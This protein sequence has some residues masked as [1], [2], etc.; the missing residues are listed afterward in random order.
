[1]LEQVSPLGVLSAHWCWIHLKALLSSPPSLKWDPIA[2][3]IKWKLSW[4]STILDL[5]P[6][7]LYRDASLTSLLKSV[8][9][10]VFCNTSLQRDS[11]QKKKKKDDK[12]MCAL[13]HRKSSRWKYNVHSMSNL[14]DKS[15]S[16]C[17][18]QPEGQPI[19]GLYSMGHILVMINL[20]MSLDQ[21]LLS[22]FSVTEPKIYCRKESCGH[23]PSPPKFTYFNLDI[24]WENPQTLWQPP[25]LKILI[26][27]TMNSFP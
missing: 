24:A 14:F 22:Y 12:Q 1:M 8:A 9:K 19:C 2:Y 7:Y 26:F 21:Y 17:R 6:K 4:D 27:Y 18:Q 5:T 23:C 16:L 10:F 25:S 3:V 11:R 15:L 20:D 13:L